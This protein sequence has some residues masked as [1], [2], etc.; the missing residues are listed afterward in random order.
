MAGAPARMLETNDL[1]ASEAYPS[2]VESLISLQYPNGRVHEVTLTTP[3]EVRPGYQFDLYG[4][5]WNAV[6]LLRLPRGCARESQ[7]MLC[8]STAALLAPEQ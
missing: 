5:R 7:R 3:A 4:R 8:R 2:G 6:G 1:A